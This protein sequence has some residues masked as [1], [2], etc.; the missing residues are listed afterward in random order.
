MSENIETSVQMFDGS[1]ITFSTK[2]ELQANTNETFIM[3]PLTHIWYP[4]SAVA[5]MKLPPEQFSDFIISTDHKKCR[6][7]LTNGYVLSVTDKRAMWAIGRQ[8]VNLFD[9]DSHYIIPFSSI[10]HIEE[11]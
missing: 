4:L 3:D 9:T 7:K 5:F 1:F 6:V 2:N 8:F 10:A 11:L